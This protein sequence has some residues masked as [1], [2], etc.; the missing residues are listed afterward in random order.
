M[1]S[2][3]V[4]G[5]WRAGWGGGWEVGGAIRKLFHR[6]RDRSGPGGSRPQGAAIFLASGVLL[7]AAAATAAGRR[8]GTAFFCVPGNGAAPCGHRREDVFLFHR[9]ASGKA[10]GGAQFVAFGALWHWAA[11][12]GSSGARSVRW[13]G[14]GGPGGAAVVWCSGAGLNG[15]AERGS[16]GES[17]V[18]LKLVTSEA[19][20]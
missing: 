4:A 2:N 8:E 20:R 9:A 6:F 11:L 18:R 16:G 5:R 12:E 17:R 1:L 3:L 13:A 14:G 19:R 7:L 15:R 10:S